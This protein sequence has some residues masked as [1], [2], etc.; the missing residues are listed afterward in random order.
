MLKDNEIN[1]NTLIDIAKKMAIAART[2]PKARGIDNT[3]IAIAEDMDINLIAEKMD[4]IS[5]EKNLPF[6]SRD[7]QNLRNA[8]TLLL[9]GTKI[10]PINLPFCGLCGMENCENKNKHP[11]IPCTFNTTDLGIATSSAASVAMDNRVD[12]RIMYTIGMAVKELG[13]MGNDVKIIYGIPL[14][15]KGKNIFFDR[16]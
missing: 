13:L 3:E 8:S 2:A 9:I 12:N 6:F 7:A 5:N 1:K 4:E 14:S 15:A 16:K 11:E 10:N